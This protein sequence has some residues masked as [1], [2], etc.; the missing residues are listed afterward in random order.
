MILFSQ[1]FAWSVLCLVLFKTSTAAQF[2]NKNTKYQS[3]VWKQNQHLASIDLLWKLEKKFASSVLQEVLI[4]TISERKFKGGGIWQ[5][6][7]Q[8]SII[9]SHFFFF[10]KQNLIFLWCGSCYA[11]CFFPKTILFSQ[12][13]AWSVLCLVVFK[14]SSSC[15][16]PCWRMLP[17]RHLEDDFAS[18]QRIDASSLCWQSFPLV[19]TQQLPRMFLLVISLCLVVFKTSKKLR[20]AMLESVAVARPLQLLSLRLKH[21]TC[22]TD[23]TPGKNAKTVRTIELQQ[24]KS[25]ISCASSTSN[26]LFD[27]NNAWGFCKKILS[28]YGDYAR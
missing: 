23:T 15:E 21:A 20:N 14:T 5:R 25:W 7:R 22:R 13:F 2:A 4:V 27:N 3:F 11:P 9:I 17:S 6:Q 16:M 19:F 8:L 18:T 28:S 1:H 12:D 26:T 24:K 10:Q